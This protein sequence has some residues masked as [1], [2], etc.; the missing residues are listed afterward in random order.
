MFGSGENARIV[1]MG[2]AVV[3]AG[4]LLFVVYSFVGTFVLGVFLYYASRPIYARLRTRIRPPTLAAA[5]A[6]FV[7]VFPV[8]LL[9]WYTAALGIGELR[10]LAELDLSGYGGLWPRTPTSR[11]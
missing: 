9:F 4:A 10:A 2:L 8:L 6:L 11:A 7:L 3:L 1:W 5:V